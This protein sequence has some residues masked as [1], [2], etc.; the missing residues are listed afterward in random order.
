MP[1]KVTSSPWAGF[2]DRAPGEHPDIEDIQRWQIH[3]F[4]CWAV[5][6]PHL[7]TRASEFAT[8]I[9]RALAFL[10]LFL[11]E[12]QTLPRPVHSEGAALSVLLSTLG[13]NL[14]SFCGLAIWGAYQFTFFYSSILIFVLPSRSPYI[15]K[16]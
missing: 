6:H 13:K 1:E 7:D 3:H 12:L 16:E 10:S 15:N 9:C 2:W 5:H 8:G 11:A 14:D 4:P